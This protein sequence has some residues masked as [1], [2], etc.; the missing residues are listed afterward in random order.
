MDD[1]KRIF[2]AYAWGSKRIL[3]SSWGDKPKVRDL[4][5]RLER[6]GFDPWLDEKDLVAGL[7]WQDQITKA[8]DEADIFL[9][10]LSKNAVDR[11]GFLQ[12][13]IRLALDAYTNRPEGS[14]F[15]IPVRLDACEIPN[16]GNTKAGVNLRDIHWV[17][18]FE[19]DGFG[20]LVAA[21]NMGGVKGV[22]AIVEAADQ[23]IQGWSEQKLARLASILRRFI[24]PDSTRDEKPKMTDVWS[25]KSIDYHTITNKKY[26]RDIADDL[27]SV[28][29]FY[30]HRIYDLDEDT[31][32]ERSGIADSPSDISHHHGINTTKEIKLALAHDD[33]LNEWDF[34][35]KIISDSEEDIVFRENLRGWCEGYNKTGESWYILKGPFLKKADDLIVRYRD[36]IDDEVKK[37]VEISGKKTNFRKKMSYLLASII[38]I[39]PIYWLLF[40]PLET[41]RLVT[42]NDFP[43]FIDKASAGGGMITQIVKSAYEQAGLEINTIEF[44]NDWPNFIQNDIMKKT[45]DASFAW[46][47]PPKCENIENFP[48][49]MRKR[50]D[51]Y[52][53][54]SIY[55]TEYAFYSKEEYL[56]DSPIIHF[57]DLY[58]KTIC[59]PRGYY[60]LDLLDVGLNPDQKIVLHEASNVN[61]CFKALDR[62]EVQIV[63]VNP[64]TAKRIIDRRPNHYGVKRIENLS[65]PAVMHLIAHKKNPKSEKI[66]NE[67]NKIILEFKKSSEYKRIIKS[68]FP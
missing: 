35:K 51:F 22:T 52:Y 25:V 60:T 15:L 24:V 63:S 45:Y 50:C 58:D 3:P 65:T 19:S 12:E 39:L 47:G 48:D 4:Y 14:I 37:F 44:I 27:L 57:V 13:E 38:L 21:I 1:K 61:E 41:P 46:Y 66:I 53:S 34:L 55:S 64:H 30:L 29:V 54:E 8:I 49:N 20:N 40:P 59:R 18:L 32:S 42:G 17:D 6:E 56:L 28:K 68:H 23:M 16:M 31:H 36:E 33:L 62:G 10:C 9:A 43:P 26:Y 5:D 67:F 7:N 2:I 11:T